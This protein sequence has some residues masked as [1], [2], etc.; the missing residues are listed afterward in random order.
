MNIQK[1]LEKNTESLKG[2]KIAVTGTTG[3]IGKELC[4]FLASLGA[5]LVLLDRNAERSAEHRKKLLESFPNAN[6]TCVPLDLEE[7]AS[8][9]KATEKLIEM[10]IDTFIHNA[11]AYSIPRHRC[12]SGYDNV[13]QI[14]FATPYYMIQKLLPTLRER[15]GKVVV[16]G[17]IAH[18]YS[19]IDEA[20]VDFHTR[21]AASKV[22]GN[23]K[24]YLMFSL[25]ELFKNETEVSL[26][27][28]HPGITFTNITA[29]Y[30]KLIFAIIKHPMKIIFM[31]PRKAAMSVLWGLFEDC[32]YCEWIGPS[33]FDVW[34]FPKK[35]SLKTCTAD[36]RKRIAELSSE[37]YSRCQSVADRY[38]DQM[39]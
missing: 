19:R 30:P 10:K 31:K 21:S 39:S 3:G 13:F 24:R 11:G 5:S 18:N 20:D 29:H 9:R 16:V 37:V 15:K 4:D 12:E 34:G 38:D 8:A 14:N 23:A 36:E 32:G 6:I 7:L 25:F 26:A 22:Y 33:V 27:V 2:K 35:K 28:T 1:W 17:S